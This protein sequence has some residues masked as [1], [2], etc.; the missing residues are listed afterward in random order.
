MS[1]ALSDFGKQLSDGTG[2]GELMDDLGHALA[3]ERD[4][5]C[6]LGG[7]QPA[8]IP[9]IEMIWSRRLREITS[10]PGAIGRVL[11]HYE[12]PAGNTD[13][14]TSVAQLFQRECGW[15]IGPENVGV[16]LGGQSAFFLLFNALAG[17]CGDRCSTG[18]CSGPKTGHHPTATISPASSWRTDDRTFGTSRTVVPATLVAWPRRPRRGRHSPTTL[19]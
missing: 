12:P 3:Q 1:W 15:Q 4:D 9:D 11:G 19:E 7:G 14:R 10:E 16:T 18:S 8:H 5:L 2:I 17:R 13:F 6:M